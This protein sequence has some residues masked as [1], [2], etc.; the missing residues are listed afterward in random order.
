[1]NAAD[2]MGDGI[3]EGRTPFENLRNAYYAMPE[4][5]PRT[6]LKA[7]AFR[8]IRGLGPS[9]TDRALDKIEEEQH[10]EK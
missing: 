4:D 8:Y 3:D 1:M 10:D 9:I 5:T 2:A 6:Q 7:F